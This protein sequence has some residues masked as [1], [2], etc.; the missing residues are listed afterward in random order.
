MWKAK[1][2]KADQ[3]FSVYIREKADWKCEYCHKDYSNNH[4]GLHASHYWGRTRESVRFDPENVNALCYFHHMKL[5]HGDGREDYRNFMI[6]RLGQKRYDLLKARAYQLK[7][8]DRAMEYLRAKALV[9]NLRKVRESDIIKPQF[10][11]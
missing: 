2:D 11:D 7:K 8:K 5:G 4:Q 1:I 10:Y 6:K 3:T 9:K